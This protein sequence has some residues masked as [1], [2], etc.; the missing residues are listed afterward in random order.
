MS[1]KTNSRVFAYSRY[2]IVPVLTA[3]LQLAY[4]VGLY[5][6]FKRL[7]I[8]ALIPLGLVY[9]VSISWNINGVSHNFLHNPYF[10]SPFLNRC[11]SCMESIACGFSQVFYENVH[12]WHHVGNADLPD[13]HG[14]TVDPLSIYKH[15]EHGRPE[16]PWTYVFLSF[17]RDDPKAMF[18]EIL[19]S[20]TYRQSSSTAEAI[21]ADPSN[22]MLARGPRFRLPAEVIRDQ[23]MYA[24]GML[25]ETLGG[26]SVRPYQPNGIWDDVSVY[27]NLH[28]YMHDV[29]KVH[30]LQRKWDR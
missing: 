6:A 8:W 29:A 21:N 2:D 12:K 27:G 22:R 10:R 18:K 3:L 24:A 7:P 19:M 1:I 20:A 9:S 25:T 14:E 16:N 11:F 13:D 5:I 4:V 28:N 30:L 26:P 17:F 15:G 23:A